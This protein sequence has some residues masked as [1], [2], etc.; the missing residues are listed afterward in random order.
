MVRC[1]PHPIIVAEIMRTR[2]HSTPPYTSST[3]RSDGNSAQSKWPRTGRSK[4]KEKSCWFSKSHHCVL[5][6][7][8]NGVRRVGVSVLLLNFLQLF[9]CFAF[10][11]YTHAHTHTSFHW[12]IGIQ[13]SV[14]TRSVCQTSWLVSTTQLQQQRCSR[15]WDAKR[16][17]LPA[18]FPHQPLS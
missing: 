17:C 4:M 5:F 12:E 10:V 7:L 13:G 9:R 6:L 16:V 14:C 15:Y 8:H 3:C 1:S 11:F 18:L 2:K